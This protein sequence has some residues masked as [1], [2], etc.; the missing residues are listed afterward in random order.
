MTYATG[1]SNASG[2]A[3]LVHLIA[4]QG[5]EYRDVLDY[6][7]PAAVRRLGFE[8]VYAPD[9]WVE[10]LPDEAAERL[11]DPSL[12]E[13]LVRDESESLYRVLPRVPRARHAAHARIVRG[14]AAGRA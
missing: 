6:L 9:A 1:R 10:G 11:N 13:L 12:F 14:P 2:F 3:G 5:P 8:Y 7:E 4:R